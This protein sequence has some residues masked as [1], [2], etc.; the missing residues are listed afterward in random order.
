MTFS[1]PRRPRPATAAIGAAALAAAFALAAC[2]PRIDARGNLP[3][4]DTVAQI[5]PGVQS[6]AEVADLLGSPSVEG[7]FDDKT[8]YYISGRTETYAFFAPKVVDQQVLVVEF[9]DAGLVSGVER[10][11]V[12]DGRAIDPVGRETPTSGQELTF[13]QQLFGNLGRF[14]KPVD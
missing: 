13:L 3:D 4:P 9:D 2:Q 7:T 11:G 10:Y 8:W 14:N 6:R 12:E 5:Q 1:P